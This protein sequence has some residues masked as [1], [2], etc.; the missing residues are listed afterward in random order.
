MVSN[1]LLS[2]SIQSIEKG[3]L[4]TCGQ[5]PN[6]QITLKYQLVQ[7]ITFPYNRHFPFDCKIDQPSSLRAFSNIQHFINSHAHTR[8]QLYT[9]EPI[10]HRNRWKIHS[11][12]I[13]N[14]NWVSVQHLSEGERWPKKLSGRSSS[15]RSF[16]WETHLG[17]SHFIKFNGF[18]FLSWQFEL[19]DC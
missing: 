18:G 1:L 2:Q 5:W 4:P 8:T 7:S 10:F 16:H 11:K 19:I 15:M 14:T 17:F 9:L 13:E 6:Q 12:I 3:I